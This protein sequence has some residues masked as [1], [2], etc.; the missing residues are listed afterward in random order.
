MRPATGDTDEVARFLT[1]HRGFNDEE[2]YSMPNCDA[3][4]CVGREAGGEAE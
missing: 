4:S 2:R 3:E 1:Q